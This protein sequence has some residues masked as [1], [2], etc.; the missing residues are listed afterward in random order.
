MKS[1]ESLSDGTIG[2]EFP[3]RSKAVPLI[4]EENRSVVEIQEDCLLNIDCHVLMQRCNQLSKMQ[5]FVGEGL[6]GR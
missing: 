4:I 1:S 5:S 3:L 6:N 2:E